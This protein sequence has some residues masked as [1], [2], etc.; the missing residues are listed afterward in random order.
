MRNGSGPG[1]F[2]L[3]QRTEERLGGPTSR[4]MHAPKI[5]GPRRGD[6]CELDPSVLI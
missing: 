2:K 6:R 1:K 4:W 3:R 5:N